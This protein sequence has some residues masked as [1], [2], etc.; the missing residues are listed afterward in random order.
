MYGVEFRPLDFSSVLGLDVVKELLQKIL[1][2]NEIDAAYL[3]AGSLSSGK[4]TLARIFARSILCENRKDDMSPCNECPSCLSFLKERNPSY[5]EIDAATTGGKD[6]VKELFEKL[7]YESV[8]KKTIILIDECHNM[9]KEAK[10]AWLK[11]LEENNPNVISIFCTTNVDKMPGTLRSRCME[12][13]FVQPVESDIVNK[14]EFIC[15]NKGLVYDKDSLYLLAQSSGRYYRYAE[16]KLSLVSNLGD[17]TKENINKVTNIYNE[18]IVDML[19]KLS[20]DVNESLKICDILVSKISISSLYESIVRLIVDTI[21]YI[22]GYMY[23]SQS[24]VELLKSMQNQYGPSLY[25]I[26]NYIVS[27]NKYTELIALQSDLLIMHYKFL[28]D[29][30]KPKEQTQEVDKTVTKKDDSIV[31]KLEEIKKLPSWQREEAI[32]AYKN[33]K[34]IVDNKN[35]VQE[36]L[37]KEWSPEKENKQKSTDKIDPAAVEAYRKLLGDI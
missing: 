6:D 25:E 34:N 37:T 27:K 18:E 33:K 30:F 4:T 9:S 28:K 17:I 26:L 14:L 13:Q 22:S 12:I 16:N 3:F 11:K 36:V 2:K 31:T 23:D 8:S 10:D 19:V 29:Q 15:K 20:Y 7:K 24:Y 32:K 35:N 21:K 1:K 5:T